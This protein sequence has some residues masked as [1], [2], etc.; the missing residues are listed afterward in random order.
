MGYM[1]DSFPPIEEL[2][3]Y[4]YL[5]FLSDIYDVSRIK[6]SSTLEKLKLDL[7]L[8]DRFFSER[9]SNLSTGNKK[10]ANFLGSIFHS[11]DLL[12]LDEPFSGI[13]FIMKN[14]MI[15]VLNQFKNDSRIVIITLHELEIIDDIF[16][17]IY[18]LNNNVLNI[19][20]NDKS[21]E[22]TIYDIFNNLK[23]NY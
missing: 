1:S 21:R 9:I 15:H 17:K 19:V 5:L 13:D 14:K 12:V 7:D 10:I 4:D 18:V 11:P 22:S 20:N 8:N 23:N 16:A 6:F 3:V 2:S